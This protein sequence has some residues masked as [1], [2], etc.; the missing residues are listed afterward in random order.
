MLRR[1]PETRAREISRSRCIAAP[2]RRQAPAARIGAESR[3]HKPSRSCLSPA[4]FLADFPDKS[5][6]DQ[7]RRQLELGA[8]SKLTFGHLSIVGFVGVAAKILHAIQHQH[9]KF[10]QS[11]VPVARAISF[12]DAGGNRYV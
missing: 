12:C 6:M 10:L 4:D 3:L 2:R 1:F 9:L 5:P 7:R 8:Q 11:L